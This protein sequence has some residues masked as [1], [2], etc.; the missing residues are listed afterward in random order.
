MQN[1]SYFYLFLLCTL[2]SC[3][4]ESSIIPNTLVNIPN[5]EP[6]I[7]YPVTP[8]C[9]PYIPI[10]SDTSISWL[11]FL[12]NPYRGSQEFGKAKAYIKDYNYY[13]DAS[14]A[15]YL[16]NGQVG[17]ALTRVHSK[18]A[19]H[20]VEYISFYIN[21]DIERCVTIKRMSRF[22]LTP[23]TSSGLYGIAD[24]DVNIAGYSPN[25]S[26]ENILEIVELDTINNHLEA[27]FTMSMVINEPHSSVFIPDTI[28][29]VNG[30]ISCDILPGN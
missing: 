1:Q 26:G 2:L 12:E 15:A 20:L 8:S 5:N 21:T 17:I 7:E 11:G 25:S 29:F 24:G 27:N 10:I 6:F 14:A 16:K 28:Q 19:H 22:D 23:T 13:W 18:V 4:K 30:M 9:I 3:V